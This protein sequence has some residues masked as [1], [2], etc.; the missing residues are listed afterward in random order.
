MEVKFT[1][2]NGDPFSNFL[3]DENSGAISTQKS[4]DRELKSVYNLTVVGKT[5]VAPYTFDIAQVIVNIEDL[6]DQAPVFTKEDSEIDILYLAADSPVGH[7]IHKVGCLDEDDGINGQLRFELKVEGDFVSAMFDIN[8]TNGVISLVSKIPEVY[9]PKYDGDKEMYSVKVIVTDNGNNP[10]ALA[11]SRTYEIVIL[12]NNTHTPIFDYSHS[13][14]S[15]SE[16]MP[17]NTEIISLAAIDNDVGAAGEIIYSIADDLNNRGKFG[18]FP[19]GRIYLKDHLDRE[20][21]AY[22]SIRVKATDFGTPSRSS[23]ATVV[24]YVVDENDNDPVLIPRLNSKGEDS[25]IFYLAE[26]EPANS[27]VGRINAVDADVGRNAELTYSFGGGLNTKFNYFTIDRSTGFIW[28]TVS[29][30]REDFHREN[31]Q[32][33]MQFDVIVSD[34]G[35]I[36]S[37]TASVTITIEIVDKNDNAPEFTEPSYETTVSEGAS[38]NTEII[39]IRAND[40]DT[41]NNGE[42]TYKMEKSIDSALFTIHS[43]S[44][45]ISLIGNLDRERKD[46]M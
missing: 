28:S 25:Y 15:V 44:G 26:N 2:S 40:I 3:I 8:R 4:I 46:V 20:T 11:N 23:D 22:H 9:Y 17:L 29:I 42:I 19:D 6:N 21:Q 37:R 41:G 34:S 31:G 36:K 12:R 39:T 38:K 16:E 33:S 27:V 24:I 30:D 45:V 14:I 18:I 1:I 5:S 32:D 35:I 43:T 13:E 7:K 10:S